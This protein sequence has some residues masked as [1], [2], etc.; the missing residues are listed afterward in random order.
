MA[1]GFH[2]YFS[3]SQKSLKKSE[4]QCVLRK[5]GNDS[6]GEEEEESIIRLGQSE[7][8]KG[9][10]KYLKHTFGLL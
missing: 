1:T 8:L 3:D 5:S 10:I 2:F 4:K 9:S 6:D 7:L